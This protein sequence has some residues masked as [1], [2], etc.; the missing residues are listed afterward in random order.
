VAA[1]TAQLSWQHS[2]IFPCHCNRGDLRQDSNCDKKTILD[3]CRNHF[4]IGQKRGWCLWGMRSYHHDLSIQSAIFF[5][6]I[7]TSLRD[8][9]EF[10]CEIL[11]RKSRWQTRLHMFLVRSFFWNISADASFG[12]H[13]SWTQLSFTVMRPSLQSLGSS[14]ILRQCFERSEACWA[15]R[16]FVS[17]MHF[18]G[19]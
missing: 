6:F 12:S 13:C 19:P 5:I 1:A 10:V 2:R 15:R 11:Q 8:S 3:S 16:A 17:V 7:N 9:R 18:Q 4:P 14:I